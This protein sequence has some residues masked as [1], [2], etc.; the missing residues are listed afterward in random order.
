[1]KEG[2]SNLSS[3]FRV[4]CIQWHSLVLRIGV[5]KLVKY[6]SGVGVALSL[7]ITVGHVKEKFVWLKGPLA[8]DVRTWR[9]HVHVYMTQKPRGREV[10]NNFA[11]KLKMPTNGGGRQKIKTSLYGCGNWRIEGEGGRGGV[12]YPKFSGRHL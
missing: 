6:V 10:Q 9:G 5:N 12:K 2:A 11:T 8:Y 4:L 3:D 7:V 1:M